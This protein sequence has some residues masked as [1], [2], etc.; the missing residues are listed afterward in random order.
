MSALVKAWAEPLVDGPAGQCHWES[1]VVQRLELRRHR[2]DA[3]ANPGRRPRRHA[4]RARR[5]RRRALLAIPAP[6]ALEPL[7]A[8]DLATDW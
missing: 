2:P 6:Q 3:L 1:R 4:R 8:S 5:L 7:R